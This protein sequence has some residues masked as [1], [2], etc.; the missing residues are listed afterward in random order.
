[1]AQGF[2]KEKAKKVASIVGNVL[3]WAFVVFSFVITILVFSAQGSAD[4]VPAIFGKSLITVSTDSM[5]GTFNA[6]DLIFMEKLEPL[7]KI[8]LEVDDVITFRAP[9]DIDGDGKTGDLNTHRIVEVISRDEAN[10]KAEYVTK[11]DY[12][13]A[14]DNVGDNPYTVQATDIVGQWTGGR[15][16]GIGKVINFLR[17]S[18]GFFLFI[19]L[20]LVA[21]FIY[22]LYRFIVILLEEKRKKNPA[23]QIS[24]EDE[25]EIKRKA[26]EEYLRHQAEEE[27]KKAAEAAE[28]A[29]AEEAA[30]EATEEK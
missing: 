14:A 19:V 25:E 27:A 30:P 26:I 21:F 8:Q 29:P 23:A 2:N 15:L 7:E 6:G 3:I 10:G 17:S 18:L 5:K 20:P 9:I 24:K 11:G 4:G 28:N 22:E 1:M 13:A 16:A 12:N